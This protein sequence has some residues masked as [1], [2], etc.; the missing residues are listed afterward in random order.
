MNHKEL[1]M[2]LKQSANAG[3]NFVLVNIDNMY[4]LLEVFF[5]EGYVVMR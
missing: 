2:R 1:G 5:L 3:G 4:N